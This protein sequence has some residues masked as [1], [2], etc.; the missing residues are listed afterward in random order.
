MLPNLANS[1]DFRSWTSDRWTRLR[2]IEVS[3]RRYTKEPTREQVEPKQ[4][5][6]QPKQPQ[7][8]IETSQVECDDQS[9][10]QDIERKQN[11]RVQSPRRF[12]TAGCNLQERKETDDLVVGPGPVERG[13]KGDKQQRGGP[14]HPV[15]LSTTAVPAS[16]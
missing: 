10:E 6:R 11:E 4:C 1:N 3:V 5:G 9:I 2:N 7:H 15:P 8:I 12:H 13:Q 14:C 16:Q